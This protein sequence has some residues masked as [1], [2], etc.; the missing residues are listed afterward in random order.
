MRFSHI[1]VW[2]AALVGVA[3]LTASS[4]LL[5]SALTGPTDDGLLMAPVTVESIAPT[6]SLLATTSAR[7]TTTIAEHPDIICRNCTE[8]PLPT[9]TTVSVEMPLTPTALPPSAQPTAPPAPTARPTRV[10]TRVPT[11]RATIPSIGTARPTATPTPPRGTPTASPASP[12]VR[13][14]PSSTVQLP[15]RTPSGPTV[16]RVPQLS[17]PTPQI[18]AQLWML[19]EFDPDQQVYRS[20]TN[21]VTWPGGEV[22]HFAPAITLDMPESPDP[23]YQVR[24]RVTAWSFISSHGVNA[25]DRDSMGQIGC[26]LR[27]QPA[28]S[29]AV[30]LGGCAYRYLEEPHVEDMHMQAHAF[31]SVG[32][33]LEMCMDIYV[34]DLGQLRTTDLVLQA[35]V[36]TEV[37]DVATGQ[38]VSDDVE[39]VT[40]P[41]AVTLVVP[42]S[43]H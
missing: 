28:P 1:P 31:W 22:L 5:V 13:A 15:T 9:A 21:E 18:R 2:L 33:P 43:A 10:P 20:A 24:A 16:T 7:I 38:V 41:F 39:I 34:Y 23:A 29:D 26:R 27:T 3:V 42:R 25:R 12:T 32:K 11:V 36:L 4:A 14:Q 40:L 37:V 35:R 19:S 17:P 30:G 8:V 6:A